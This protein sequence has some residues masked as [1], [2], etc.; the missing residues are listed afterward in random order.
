MRSLRCLA[1]ISACVTLLCSA[2]FAAET[3]VLQGKISSLDGQGVADAEVYLYASKNTRRP[4]DFIS[5]KS[6]T[7]G[8]YRMVLP[9]GTYW[10]VARIKKGERFGPL[11]PGDRHSGEPVRIAPEGDRELT[12][13]FTV[14]DMQELAQKREKSREELVELSG[15]LTDSEGKGV[16]GAYVYARTGLVTATLP[17]YIS[18]WT[19]ESGRYRLKLPAGHYF[20]GSATIFPTPGGTAHIREIEL[21]AGKLPVAIDLQIPVE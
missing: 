1:L 16:A 6:D 7:R 20:L 19:D 5:P 3:F 8:S 17:E 15:T 9:Q 13:D 18:A 14:A 12:Q 21:P 11:M 2:A 4:A 10:A